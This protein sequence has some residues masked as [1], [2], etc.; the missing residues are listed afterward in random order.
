MFNNLLS[1][2]AVFDT[3]IDEEDGGVVNV[4]AKTLDMYVRADLVIDRLTGVVTGRLTGVVIGRLT[5]MVIDRLTGVVI[6]RLVGGMMGVDMLADLSMVVVV[7]VVIDMLA[8]T[9]ANLESIVVT[10]SLTISLRCCC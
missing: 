8:A 9:I 5:G 4:S 7:A 3:V 10:V 1:S 2:R 6:G